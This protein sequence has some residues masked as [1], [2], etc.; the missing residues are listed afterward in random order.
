MSEISWVKPNLV[1]EIEFTEWT[2][3]GSLRHPSFQ[4]FD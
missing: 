3:D 4:D 1:A 2:T